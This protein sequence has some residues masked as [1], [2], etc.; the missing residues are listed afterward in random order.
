M[1]L[2]QTGMTRPEPRSLIL[3]LD[4]ERWLRVLGLCLLELS[5]SS[6]FCCDGIWET[7]CAPSKRSR[8]AVHLVALD[9]FPLWEL[10]YEADF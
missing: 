1:D 7:D 10:V 9:P 5:G 4:I 8:W 3:G 6:P 2:R